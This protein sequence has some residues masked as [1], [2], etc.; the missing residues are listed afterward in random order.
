MNNAGK[1]SSHCCFS[2]LLWDG[3]YCCDQVWRLTSLYKMKIFYIEYFPHYPQTQLV[4]PVAFHF[5]TTSQLHCRGKVSS[6]VLVAKSHCGGFRC[7]CL[8]SGMSAG[9]ISLYL[10]RRIY[11]WLSLLQVRLWY[12]KSAL[13]RFQN[14]FCFEV[15]FQSDTCVHRPQE[16]GT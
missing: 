16:A 10:H 14:C 4:F 5:H 8:Q 9:W 13:T 3:D 6:A 2:L 7:Y 12:V 1:W 11:A 15:A